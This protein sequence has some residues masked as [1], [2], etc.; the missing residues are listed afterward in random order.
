[1]LTDQGIEL[2]DV[3][4]GPM[5][6]M[7]G[8]ARIAAQQTELEPIADREERLATGTQASRWAIGTE[9]WADPADGDDEAQR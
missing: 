8:S 4:V 9:R 3:Y 7:T 2:V 1:M 6:V 5:G